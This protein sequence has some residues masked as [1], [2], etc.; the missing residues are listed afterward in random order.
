MQCEIPD[1]ILQ[2][3]VINMNR[4]V[5]MDLVPLNQL[6][7]FVAHATFLES[8]SKGGRGNI[9]YGGRYHKRDETK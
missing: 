7:H 6:L 3:L 9:V 2:L 1:A 5:K 8:R 4:Y